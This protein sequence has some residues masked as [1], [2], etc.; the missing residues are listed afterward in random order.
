MAEKRFEEEAWHGA[1]DETWQEGQAWEEGADHLEGE[2]EEEEM[3]EAVVII[4]NGSGLCKVGLSTDQMPKFIFNEVLGR[5]RALWKE[6]MQ[7]QGK[8]M[9]DFYVADEP[10]G[11]LMVFVRFKGR[12]SEVHLPGA[13]IGGWVGNWQVSTAPTW[14]DSTTSKIFKASRN[15]TPT[16]CG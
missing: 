4:D 2:E 11:F 6:K 8:P 5:P 7:K 3:E 12:R 16:V 10:P 13:S 9:K 1:D 15:P 14:Q